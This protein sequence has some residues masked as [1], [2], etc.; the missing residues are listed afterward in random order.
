MLHIEWQ[1]QDGPPVSEP[2]QRGFAYGT[3][4]RHPERGAADFIIRQYDDA[5]VTFTITAFSRPASLLA[6][7]AGQAIQHHFTNRYLRAV[8]S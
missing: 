1:E 8:A 7:A 2:A 5:T 6:K 4:P 3:L